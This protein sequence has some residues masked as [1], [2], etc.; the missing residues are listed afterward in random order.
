MLRIEGELKNTARLVFRTE[1]IT[2][3]PSKQNTC[4]KSLKFTKDFSAL[5]DLAHSRDEYVYCKWHLARNAS[6]LGIKP[7]N[8]KQPIN[9]LLKSMIWRPSMKRKENIYVILQDKNFL[10]LQNDIYA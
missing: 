4:C 2:N 10:V 5:K 3:Y 6:R 7:A 8:A 1:G 9:H